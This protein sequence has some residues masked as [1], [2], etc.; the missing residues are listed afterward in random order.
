MEGIHRVAAT[1]LPGGRQV[2]RA[3]S[4][5]YVWRGVSGE[6]LCP[7]CGQS[8]KIGRYLFKKAFLLFLDVWGLGNRGMF[9]TLRDLLLRPGFLIRD[10]ISGMQM[11]YFPPFKL[12]FLLTALYLVVDSGVN[13]KDRN[14]MLTPTTE[15]SDEVEVENDDMPEERTFAMVGRRLGDKI[16]DIVEKYPNTSAL[17]MLFAMSVF[18]YFFVRRSPNIPDLRF[19]EMIVAMVYIW[20]MYFMCFIAFKFIN[21]PSVLYNILYL[22]PIVPLKQ[23]TGFS[24]WR[25]V[26]VALL[27]YLYVAIII[28]MLFAGYYLLYGFTE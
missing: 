17:T 5:P 24:W 12:L 15:Q 7:R 11:A 3:A 8:A 20:N 25:I 26:W 6:L 2:P 28:F 10:Y 27:S 19:S 21:A 22:S 4:L 1:P 14:F 13:L 23:M 16:N 9:R 18:I